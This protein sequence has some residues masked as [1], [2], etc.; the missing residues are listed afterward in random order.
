MGAGASRLRAAGG[1]STWRGALHGLSIGASGRNIQFCKEL[2][3]VG[4]LVRELPGFP[5]SLALPGA[6]G[7]RH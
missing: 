2:P 6:G 3:E 7:R 5:F 4:R 1:D